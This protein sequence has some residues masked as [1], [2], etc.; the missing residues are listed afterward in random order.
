MKGTKGECDTV[1]CSIEKSD[2]HALSLLE[3]IVEEGSN[4]IGTPIFHRAKIITERR[5]CTREDFVQVPA[6]REG[7]GP[8]VARWCRQALTFASFPLLC[9]REWLHLGI[10]VSGLAAITHSIIGHQDL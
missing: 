10:L 3:R 8:L 5:G 1:I 7:R 6:K 4:G 9:P 2:P